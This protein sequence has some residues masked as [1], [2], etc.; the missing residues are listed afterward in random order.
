VAGVGLGK[1]AL[2]FASQVTVVQFYNP[3]FMRSFGSGV[4]NG[5][6]WTITVELQFY[7]LVPLLY[8]LVSPLARTR[9]QW[10]AFLVA[11]TLVFLLANITFHSLAG[12]Y[13][14]WLESKVLALTTATGYGLR[15]NL[16]SKL[17]GCT[18][19]PW[20]YMFLVGVM[21]QRNFD[22]VQ[23]ILSGR[24]ALLIPTYLGVT[25]LGVRVFGFG[26][27]NS[28][29]PV[30]YLLLAATVF[31]C[32]YSVPWL[33]EK[34]LHRNDFSYG[35]YIYHIPVINLL[36]Y[37]GLSSEYK[38]LLFALAATIVAAVLSWIIVERPAMKLKKH[39][40]VSVLQTTRPERASKTA[41]LGMASTTVSRSSERGARDRGQ[42]I[43]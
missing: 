19:I 39:P 42:T 40:L 1:L 3:E 17:L 23:R 14:A 31:S 33:S 32:A 34:L 29:N 8:R 15:P 26:G 20:F 37:C 11:T 6:L 16:A 9:A 12:G 2:W 10:N 27:G 21:A 28:I 36:M 18:F 38:Y 35:V 22:V 24:A 41:G 43:K 7:V 5:S 13:P 30:L 25:Y 4:L